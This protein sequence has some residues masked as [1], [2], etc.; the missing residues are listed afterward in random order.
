MRTQ[1]KPDFL[2][3]L[4]V[5]ALVTTGLML[6]LSASS[7]LAFNRYGDA[8]Y[9]VK[10]QVLFGLLGVLAMGWMQG[11]PLE[12]LRKAAPWLLGFSIFLLLL[13][14]VPGLGRRVGGARRW[15]ALGPL[16]FQPSEF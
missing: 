5:L 9:F 1:G 16:R 4:A 7:I 15:L 8:L 10:R 14:L 2:M 13:V 12:R 6:I 11:I 3:A